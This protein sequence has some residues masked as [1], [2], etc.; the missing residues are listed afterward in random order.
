MAYAKPYPVLLG[1]AVLFLFTRP[2]LAFGA[3]NIA[4]ISK[5]EGQNCK[6]LSYAP[7][8]PALPL[9]CRCYLLALRWYTDE[10]AF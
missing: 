3:G 9:L 6:L 4:G 8:P 7:A 5:V 1:I 10:V 2:A